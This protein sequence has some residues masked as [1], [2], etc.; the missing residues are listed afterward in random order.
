ML[1]MTVYLWKSGDR[2]KSIEAEWCA[3]A[4][5][6][7]LGNYT[8]YTLTSRNLRVKIDGEETIISPSYYYIE[9]TGW[10]QTNSNKCV[11]EN[12]WSWNF[13]E[14]IILWY[15]EWYA[16]WDYN[17][18]ENIEQYQIVNVSNTC[19]H[20]KP[21]LWFYR[22]WWSHT[23]NIDFIRMNKWFTPREVKAERVFFMHDKNWT[24]DD[25]T[26]LLTWNIIV[27]LCSNESCKWRKEIGKRQID[28]RSQT[29]SF[30]KCRYYNEPTG[31]INDGTETNTCKTREDCRVYNPD[32]PTLCDQ[33]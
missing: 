9:L 29:I 1:W 25:D 18:D 21:H 17:P 16:S 13:C 32:D 15:A 3:N 6:W 22:S 19:R 30:K 8:Y 11:P 5:G 2:A 33:Y 27:V 14:D 31:S 24:T 7:A 20:G 26:K 10:N 23:W 4:L 28:A 12:I